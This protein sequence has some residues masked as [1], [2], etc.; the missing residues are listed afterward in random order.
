MDNGRFRVHPSSLLSLL[1]LLG[2]LLLGWLTLNYPLAFAGEYS[3]LAGPAF[4][5]VA[6]HS[7]FFSRQIGYAGGVTHEA[8]LLAFRPLAGGNLRYLTTEEGLFYIGR[9]FSYNPA[10]GTRQYSGNELL[11]STLLRIWFTQRF[12]LG[13]GPFLAI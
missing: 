8:R 1:S 11:L 2:F 4:G 6:G 3:F 12:S 10:S 9:R 5:R 7:S 13:F